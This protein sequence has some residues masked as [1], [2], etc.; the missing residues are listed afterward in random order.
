MDRF[1]L[2]LADMTVD[3]EQGPFQM[4]N[5]V[6]SLTEETL[7]LV[8]W[9]GGLVAEWWALGTQR[10]DLTSEF[11]MNLFDLSQQAGRLA[12]QTKD[13]DLTVD[14]FGKRKNGFVDRA[15]GNRQFSLETTEEFE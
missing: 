1:Q 4:L 8:G 5:A 14:T 6:A 2:E 12:V 10:G 11:A 3:V 13:L 7:Q 9:Q 15:A